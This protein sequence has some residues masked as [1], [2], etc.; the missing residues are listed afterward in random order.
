MSTMQAG[1]TQTFTRASMLPLYLFLAAA[2]YLVPTSLVSGPPGFAQPDP[3]SSTIWKASYSE[4]Y[5]GCVSTVLWPESEKPVA[6]VVVQPDGRMAM[7][8][9]EEARASAAQGQIARTIGACRAV[10]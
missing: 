10:R 2:A 4:R 1:F 3:G 9:R 8:S 7:V 5:P 6:L